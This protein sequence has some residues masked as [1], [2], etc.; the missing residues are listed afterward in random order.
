MT[1]LFA[2]DTNIAIYAFSQDERTPKAFE[3]LAAG[4]CI[5]VQLLNEFVS[6]SLRK[7]GSDWLEISESLMLIE[8]LATEI[9][10]LTLQVH[11]TAI[12][13]ARRHRFSFYDSL[14]IAAALI[15]G[16]DV[17]YSEDMH[18]GLVIDDRL[19]IINPFLAAPE[20]L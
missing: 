5:S 9:S 6:V 8:S 12:A 15:I 1:E 2:I 16:C 11:E 10:P 19:T 18:H 20:P 13:L 4:P 17:F 14:M 3:L 7:R